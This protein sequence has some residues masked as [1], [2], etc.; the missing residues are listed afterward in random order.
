[1]Y[2]ECVLEITRLYGLSQDEYDVQRPKVIEYVKKRLDG[3]TE[4]EKIHIK[5]LL[6]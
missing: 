4:F 3:M 2:D 5:A 1:V 6:Q